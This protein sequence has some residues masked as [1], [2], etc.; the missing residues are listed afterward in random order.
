M[1]T[2]ERVAAA[3]RNAGRSGPGGTAARLASSPVFGM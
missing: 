3:V 2:L 1:I